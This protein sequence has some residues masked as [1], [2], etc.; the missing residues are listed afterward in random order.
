MNGA[1]YSSGDASEGGGLLAGMMAHSSRANSSALAGLHASN[2]NILATGGA[3][4]SSSTDAAK[5]L[6]EAIQHRGRHQS[7]SSSP[8]NAQP[9]SEYKNSHQAYL[10]LGLY[11]S[12]HIAMHLFTLL[13]SD[14]YK[15]RGLSLKNLGRK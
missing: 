9:A 13:G 10:V 6:A 2:R 4:Y 14:A 15:S 5:E 11:L 8:K 7:Q 3:G 1:G 12:F